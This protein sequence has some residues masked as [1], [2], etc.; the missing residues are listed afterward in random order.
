[1]VSEEMINLQCRPCQQYGYTVVDILLSFIV[2]VLVVDN[3][4]TQPVSQGFWSRCE[5]ILCPHLSDFCD[6]RFSD[7]H[8]KIRIPVGPTNYYITRFIKTSRPSIK[9]AE[10]TSNVL[11]R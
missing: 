7:P 6:Q 1:M 8:T 9:V 10:G 11:I 2:Y 4:C 3:R 5:G